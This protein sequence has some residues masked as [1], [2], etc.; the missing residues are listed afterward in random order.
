[1]SESARPS[2]S[3]WMRGVSGAREPSMVGRVCVV[4]GASRGIGRATALALARLGASVVM[5][6]RDE[7]R[8]ARA[9]DEVKHSAE[10]EDVSLVV[11]DLASFASI[12]TAAREIGARWPAIH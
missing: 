3:E 11:G 1:M 8:G 10:S 5:M 12:R 4:T 6:V 2:Y 9:V 7:P